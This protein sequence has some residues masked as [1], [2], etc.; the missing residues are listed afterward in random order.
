[1]APKGHGNIAH[2]LNFGQRI[3]KP[4]CILQPHC[5]FCA[6]RYGNQSRQQ[7]DYQKT[8]AHLTI[9]RTLHSVIR[10]NRTQ[11]GCSIPLEEYERTPGPLQATRLR[12][13][14]LYRS[15]AGE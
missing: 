9:F 5:R 15:R 4:I 3:V 13:G 10:S 2:K 1:M 6:A 12:V 7:G 11:K 14:Y 8:A